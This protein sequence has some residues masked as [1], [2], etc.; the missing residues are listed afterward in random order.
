MGF[1][2]DEEAA[3]LLQAEDESHP[4]APIIATNQL[5]MYELDEDDSPPTPRF[6]QDQGAYRSWRWMPPSLRR[7]GN[8]III[9]A[10]GPQPPQI[11]SIKPWFPSIQLAPVRLL[12]TYLPK[13][14][15][16]VVLLL[17]FYSSWLLTFALILRESTLV[18][19]VEGYG[20]PYE[21]GC[22]NTFWGP[23]NSCGLDGMNCRPFYNSSFAFRCPAEC[24]R[25]MVLNFRAV[26]AQE[27][28]YQPL[29]IGGPKEEDPH[30][31]PIYRGDSFI[32]GAGIHAGIID[33]RSGGCGVVSVMGEG[34]DYASTRRNG[35]TSIGFDS[36]FPLS[37]T[38]STLSSCE[39]KDMR[40]PLFI[41]SL[42]YT[43]IFSLF[44]TSPSL[45]FYTI[46]TA[47]FAHVGFASD[48]PN[49]S[50]MAGLFSNLLGKFLPAMFCAFVI[51]RYCVKRTLKGL[52]AQIEKTILWVG[53][54]WFGA[55]SNYTLDW[56]PIQRLTP[57]DLEQQPGAKLALALIIIMLVCI[58][59]QQA[60]YF[61]LEGRM[62]HYLALYGLFVAGILV[63]L[64]IPGLNLR[65]HHYILA[66]LLIPGTSMQTRPVLFYQGL[67]VG[68]FIN[69]VARWGFDS[70]L[71]TP[72]ALQGDAPYY[73]AL[74]TPIEPIIS[75]GLAASNI[76]FNWAF[77]PAPYDGF[78]VLVNDVERFRGFVDE[79]YGA[80]KP[81]VWSR[82]PGLAEPE[83][84]RF[85]YMQG[86]INGDYSRA[87][88]WNPDGS[89][90]E[91]EPGP[92]RV[93]TRQLNDER[94]G[95]DGI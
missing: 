24:K 25:R 67:L 78:S 31:R 85:G 61:R 69:G 1:T 36:Y 63:S 71:Q 77:P 79:G 81:F 55:L 91:M 90:L 44:T 65:I 56:I 94:I 47:V 17:G 74:P 28:V 45:F 22:G 38:F 52:T 35:I 15:Q 21:I 5:P 53:G 11:Q 26:G 16:K 89:W 12:D 50:S 33:N 7:I 4:D 8:N 73:S 87:G 10:K 58:V 72:G 39:A 62:P 23:G 6:L 95:K 57:H 80:G 92:S 30:G 9:F 75:L 20:K 48:P 43:T 93:K 46:F 70:V 40:W 83:Y 66:L 2:R 51:Y 68:L 88:I 42:T 32:C 14:W 84:F 18:G 49:H 76:S 41:V 34:R 29:V 59:V 64:V 54:C 13:K 60:H 86:N 27:I 37:F 19:E 82:Q 3:N